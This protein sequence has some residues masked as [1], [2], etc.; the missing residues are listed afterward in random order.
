MK[1]RWWT[2]AIVGGCLMLAAFWPGG[3]CQL[4]LPRNPLHLRSWSSRDR[5]SIRRVRTKRLPGPA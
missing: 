3:S 1:L 5:P 2:F 4:R